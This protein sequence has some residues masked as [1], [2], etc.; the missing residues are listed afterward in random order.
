M[1][2]LKLT[3]P[4]HFDSR[5]LRLPALVLTLSLALL[6]VA[7]LAPGTAP[8]ASTKYR[9][10]GESTRNYTPN[11]GRKS[12]RNCT[13]EGRVTAYQSKAPGMRNRPF[14]VPFKG[15][16]VAWSITLANPTRK[17]IGNRDAELPFFNGIFGSPSQARIAVLKRVQKKKKGPPRYKMVR[18]SPVQVLNPYFG[19]TVQFALSKPLNVIENQ[20]VALTIP[21]W[22]P[23]LWRTRA[24]DVTAA[25]SQVNANVCATTA[26]THTWRGSRGPKKCTLGDE[27]PEQQEKNV[28]GSHPQQ[29][30]D[31]VKRYG[32]YYGSNV[33]LYTA[34]LVG[35]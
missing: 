12:N 7:F 18:Q 2:N 34:T 29:K 33:L 8:A 28:A 23:N 25:G 21:T 24:C 17:A 1:L 26:E 31:S 32:C 20:V 5:N 22:A 16:I 35:R 10:L 3:L 27:S 13:A 14:V 6:A 19:T 11:C 4:E 9:V 15:K 30:V